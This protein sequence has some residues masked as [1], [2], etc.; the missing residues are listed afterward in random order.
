M[1]GGSQS[2]LVQCN[3][4][5]FYVAKFLG[6]PQ[7]SRTL[8]NEFLS[9]HFIKQLGVSTPEIRLL[10]LPQSA[11]HVEKVFFCI[12][13]SR[14]L[15]QTGLHVGSMCPVNPEE[16]AI[17]DCLP[18]IYLSRITNIND[19]A[20]MFVLDK[21]LYQTDK[22]QAIYIRDRNVTD[23]IS[24]RAYFIDHGFTFG[25]QQWQFSEAPLHG[26]A[27]PRSI[28]SLLDM[29]TLTT[30]AVDRVEAI[31][32]EILQ[33]PVDGIPASWLAPGDHGRLTQLLLAL[34]TRRKGLRALVSRTLDALGL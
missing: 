29:R 27:Y 8:V 13:S 9:H 1:R 17:F 3:D 15:P 33:S 6:N 11:E 30:A 18:S 22:R 28:Y 34:D 21:W 25:G 23:T 24:F 7:G 19:F 16:T 10:D 2:Q 26:L 5:Q 32:G 4:D 31:P 20:T 14:V 12:G